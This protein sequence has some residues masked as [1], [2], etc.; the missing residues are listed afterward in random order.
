MIADE[1]LLISYGN[2]MVFLIGT[3]DPETAHYQADE[4]LCEL[5]TEL[6]YAG[7]VSRYRSV[8]KWYA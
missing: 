1:E 3:N 4:L 6:G 5:L 8:E 2:R 7:V